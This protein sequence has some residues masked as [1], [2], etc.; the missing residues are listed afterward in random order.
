M[1]FLT[2][3]PGE[4]PKARLKPLP[5][6]RWRLLH[7][8]A[9][10]H[11]SSL[12]PSLIEAWGTEYRGPATGNTANWA[13]LRLIDADIIGNDTGSYIERVYEQL[14]ATAETLVGKPRVTRGDDGRLTVEQDSLQFSSAKATPQRPGTTICPTW[15]PA[16]TGIT[17]TASTDTL[18]LTAHGLLE[19]DSV[20][21]SALTGGA[22]L[23]TGT[24]YYVI[25]SGLTADAFK[26]SATLGGSAVDF[27]TNITAATLALY[28][29]AVLAEESA[30]D[31][32]A[33]RRITRRYVTAGLIA[34]S[35]RDVEDGFAEVTYTS[36]RTEQTPPGVVVARSVQNP[37]GVPVYTVTAR[38]TKAGGGADSLTYS[39]TTKRSFTLPG[40]LKPFIRTKTVSSPGSIPT[41][42]DIS[43][44]NIYQAA[45][46]QVEVDATITIS[47]TTT[48]T[49]GT[50]TPALWNPTEWATVDFDYI[51]RGPNPVNYIKEWP[52]YCVVA[53]SPGTGTATVSVTTDSL[54]GG[55]DYNCMGDRL[56]GS[57]THTIT[58]R[59]PESP[60]NTAVTLAADVRPAFVAADG[61]RWYRREIVT[62]TLPANTALPV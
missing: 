45:P 31:D 25:A 53:D 62:A 61:T 1:A 2:L 12:V 15:P 5:D 27:T 49:V 55:V 59:G 7:Y 57:N 16:Y 47:Y 3:R 22:G 36:V 50:L 48:A 37:G 35:T 18:T 19:N 28:L 6:G 4:K 38:G 20:R 32:G 21:F 30:P 9:V 43:T 52:G 58:V 8:T 42:F 14:S 44:I 29:S 11:D 39:Y 24:T 33:L 17:G 23:A 41:T 56:Y 34:T 46:K 13:G 10:S 60:A 26:L 40:R 51:A 54:A